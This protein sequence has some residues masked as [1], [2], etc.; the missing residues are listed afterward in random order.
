LTDSAC[1]SGRT[2]R[3][4]RANQAQGCRWAGRIIVGNRLCCAAAGHSIKYG[5]RAKAGD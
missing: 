4:P 3:A 2:F 1:R 5:Q